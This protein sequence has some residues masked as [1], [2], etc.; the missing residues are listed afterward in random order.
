MSAN[1]SL[2]Q[3]LT[4]PSHLPSPGADSSARLA[5]EIAM[6]IKPAAQVADEYGLTPQELAHRL[7]TDKQLRLQV[8]EYAAIWNSP[9]HA[10]ERVRIKAACMAEDALMDVW[11]ILT[12][13]ELNPSVR[14]DAHKHLTKLADV[15]PRREGAEGGSR[16]SVTI[17]LPG[18]EEM[19]ISAGTD[20]EGEVDERH[21]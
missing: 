7:K 13:G 15:E 2:A 18:R 6:K 16:F 3:Q 4:R 17:N 14:L 21:D 19:V 8:A 1:Q 12:N 10:K 9:M 5:L 20:D 11:A